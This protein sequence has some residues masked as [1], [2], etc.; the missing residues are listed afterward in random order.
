MQPFWRA[1]RR[2]CSVLVG[3]LKLNQGDGKGIITILLL[4]NISPLVWVQTVRV[5]A[6][7]TDMF[8][9]DPIDD[10]VGAFDA[11]GVLSGQPSILFEVL[12]GIR[13]R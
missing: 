2:I 10:A 7:D 4:L 8:V 1:F 13:P 3:I 6:D 12:V 5:G 11:I 9:T